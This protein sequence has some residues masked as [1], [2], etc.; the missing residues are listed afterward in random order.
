MESD[1]FETLA[2]YF[3]VIGTIPHISIKTQSIYIPTYFPVKW[4]PQKD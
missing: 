2:Q 3:I 1:Q 4:N